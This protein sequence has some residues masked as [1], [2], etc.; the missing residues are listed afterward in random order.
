MKKTSFELV[1]DLYVK[2]CI[3]LLNLKVVKNDLSREGKKIKNAQ[4]NIPLIFK[5]AAK[6]S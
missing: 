1:I 5:T 3:E 2:F 6:S 4:N